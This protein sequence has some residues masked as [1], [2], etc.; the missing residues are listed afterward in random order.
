MSLIKE[1]KNISKRLKYK[2]KNNIK[3]IFKKDIDNLKKDL[4]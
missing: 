3:Y 4:L 1:L 2:P